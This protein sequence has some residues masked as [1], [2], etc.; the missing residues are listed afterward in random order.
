MA[1]EDSTTGA[2]VGQVLAVLGEAFEGPPGPWSYFTDNDPDAGLLG[3][4]AGLSAEE[5][6]R[7][8]GD[9]TVAA[10]AHHVVFGLKASSAWIRG[11]RTPRDWAESWRVR[12]VDE[13]DWR[14]LQGELRAGYEELRGAIER[15]AA[16]GPEAMGGAVGALAHAAYHLGAI[17]RM[18]AADRQP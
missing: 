14:R 7:P 11:D 3:T 10:H 2:A 15:H 17:R 16:S 13:D 12:E 18:L 1:G 5:A 8:R 4:V 6:S 9:T